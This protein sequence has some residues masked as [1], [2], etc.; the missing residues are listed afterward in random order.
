M[1]WRSHG[2][3]T[4]A[5]CRSAVGIVVGTTKFGLFKRSETDPAEVYVHS[6]LTYCCFEISIATLLAASTQSGTAGPSTPAPT[7]TNRPPQCSPF[8]TSLSCLIRSKWPTRGVGMHSTFRC[9]RTSTGSILGLRK[10]SNNRLTSISTE[11]TASAP[12]GPPHIIVSF[13]YSFPCVESCEASEEESKTVPRMPVVT[14][15]S[16]V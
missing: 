8:K 6:Y 14:D 16:G 12:H 10:C 4:D 11:G 7:T 3:T 5:R 13:V 9:T 2:R 15:G 1:A